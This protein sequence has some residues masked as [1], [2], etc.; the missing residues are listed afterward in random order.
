M[1]DERKQ[2]GK[3]E[4]EREAEETME[5][6]QPVKADSPVTMFSTQDLGM[7]LG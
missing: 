7:I 5:W 2:A 1:V 4:L 6:I 3:L